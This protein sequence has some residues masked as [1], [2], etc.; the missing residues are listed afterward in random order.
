VAAR[1][2]T[3]HQDYESRTDE[4]DAAVRVK[5]AIYLYFKSL[6]PMDP[7]AFAGQLSRSGFICT[8]QRYCL[9]QVSVWHEDAS[10]TTLSMKCDWFDQLLILVNS[11]SGR[12]IRLLPDDI[13]VEYR[14]HSDGPDFRCRRESIER[15]LPLNEEPLPPPF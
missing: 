3:L 2:N 8:Q 11:S 9:Y 5:V 14:R 10:R 12:N 7:K 1:D 6:L 15:V 4:L 13:L